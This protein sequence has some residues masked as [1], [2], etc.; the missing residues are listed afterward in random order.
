MKVDP[1]PTP[2]PLAVTPRMGNKFCLIVFYSIEFG[3]TSVNKAL[4]DGMDSLG[5]TLE[6]ENINV[7]DGFNTLA[8]HSQSKNSL[9]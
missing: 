3:E 5:N 7:Q 9:G 6:T 1:L 2:P 4:H 8:H